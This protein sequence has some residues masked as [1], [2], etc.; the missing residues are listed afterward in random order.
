MSKE[1][2]S[3][4]LAEIATLEDELLHDPRYLK[5]CKLRELHSLYESGIASAPLTEKGMTREAGDKRP[6]LPK[7][8]QGR[9]P[10]EL[11]VKAVALTAGFLQGRTQPIPTR[12]IYAMLLDHG[13]DV[14]GKEP[15]SNLSAILSKSDE[16]RPI[17]RS[18]WVLNNDE[19]EPSLSTNESDAVDPDTNPSVASDGQIQPP[20]ELQ[21]DGLIV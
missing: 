6:L 7:E 15:V 2:L 17:G 10:S 3:S 4:M 19:P 21:D 14:G 11:R 8:S 16:F 18:G 9:Q 1:F 20:K 5:L 12:D 13:V